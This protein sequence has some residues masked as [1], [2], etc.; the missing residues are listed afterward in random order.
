MLGGSPITLGVGPIAAALS[1]ICVFVPHRSPRCCP[2]AAV[3]PHCAAV[4]AAEPNAGNGEV[5]GGVGEDLG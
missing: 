4:G 5:G 3:L 2:I 1:P